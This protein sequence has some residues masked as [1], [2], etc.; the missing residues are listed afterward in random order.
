VPNP[1]FDRLIAEASARRAPVPIDQAKLAL[2]NLF[3]EFDLAQ[4]TLVIR[5][6]SD[7]SLTPT[8]WIRVVRK[9]KERV[10][11]HPA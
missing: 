3:D 8:A 4:E 10:D 9:A 6:G 11:Q 2:G 7:F 1:D 5:G